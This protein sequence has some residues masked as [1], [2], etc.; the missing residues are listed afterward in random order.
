METEKKCAEKAEPQ[1][2][3]CESTGESWQ[4]AYWPEDALTGMSARQNVLL[5]RGR[6]GREELLNG[7]F[8]NYTV[9]C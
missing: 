7:F 5:K 1:I 8:E 2:V 9:V 4:V 3:R 6:L